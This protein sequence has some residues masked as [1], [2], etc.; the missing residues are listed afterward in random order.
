M[1]TAPS[2]SWVAECA[3]CHHSNP[4]RAHFCSVCGAPLHSPAA[5]AAKATSQAGAAAPETGTG[6]MAEPKGFMLHF[7]DDNTLAIAPRYTARDPGDAELDAPPAA[8]HGSR[9]GME[10]ASPPHARH[11]ARPAAGATAPQAH[12]EF[13]FSLPG[14]QSQGGAPAALPVPAARGGSSTW[15]TATV[16]GAM[17]ALTALVGSGAYLLGRSS[18]NAPVA[19][20][21]EAAQPALATAAALGSVSGTGVV[22]LVPRLPVTATPPAGDSLAQAQQALALADAATGRGAVAP[23][24]PALQPRTPAPAP[25]APAQRAATATAIAP[26]APAARAPGSTPCNA[27]VAALGLC[28]P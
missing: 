20:G 10:Q 22:P 3:A 6:E 5:A 21:G 7:N 9:A 23:L 17:L 19:I 12:A 16:A 13:H 26:A 8:G 25:A 14:P 24:A 2:A 15:S 18:A 4:A 28:E 27:T 11:E 1:P